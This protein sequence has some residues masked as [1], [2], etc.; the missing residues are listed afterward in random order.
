[1]DMTKPAEVGSFLFTITAS[2]L[3]GEWRLT[4]WKPLINAC[5]LVAWVLFGSA[6]VSGE[7]LELSVTEGDGELK[8]RMISVLDAPAEYVYRVV[9]DYK[10]GNRIHPSITGVEI[11]RS[12]RD[13]VIRVKNRSEHRVGLF[14]FEIEWVGDI[15]E[16]AHSRIKIS[17]IPEIGSFHSGAALWEIRPL[18][19]RTWVLHESTLKPKSF[20]IPI[21]GGYVMKKHMKNETVATFNRIECNA[22]IMS[23]MDMEGDPEHLKVALKEKGNCIQL[24]RYPANQQ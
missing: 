18:G 24:H 11:L 3:A 12:G 5:V 15:V 6:S 21:I 7:I 19:E 4:I 13:G 23:E 1:M 16:T 22:K 8:V 14:P 9:T 2:K 17:T 20:V 10:H